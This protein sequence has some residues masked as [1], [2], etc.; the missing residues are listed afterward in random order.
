MTRAHFEQWATIFQPPDEEELLLFDDP[1][2][3]H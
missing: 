2:A 1:A 3:E